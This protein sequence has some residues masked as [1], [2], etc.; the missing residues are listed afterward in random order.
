MLHAL[1]VHGGAEEG[2]AVIF[3]RTER[4]ETLVALLA[5]IQTGC[6]TMYPEEGVLD[7]LGGGPFAGGDGVGRRD[8][9]VDLADAEPD[10]VP[11]L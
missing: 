8:V 1:G 9:A 3:R 5:V 7:K 2:D 4:L 11:V 10:V 6:H